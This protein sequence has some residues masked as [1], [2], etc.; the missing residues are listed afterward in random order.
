MSKHSKMAKQ[1]SCSVKDCKN[2]I[3]EEG[4]CIEHIQQQLNHERYKVLDK[5]GKLLDN[6]GHERMT[7]VAEGKLR[8]K[9]REL[10]DMR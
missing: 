7:A 4:M 1:K 2:A 5:I 10:R 6:L 9:L 8:Q 3:G